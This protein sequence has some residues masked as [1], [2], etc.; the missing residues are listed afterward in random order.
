M[1]RN[2]LRHDRSCTNQR[3]AADRNVRQDYC[4]RADRCAPLHQNTPHR[5]VAR[6]LQGARR[7]DGPWIPVIRENRAGTDESASFDG[8]PVKQLSAILDLHIV[9]H[10]HRFVDIN[11]FSQDASIADRRLLAYLTLMPYSRPAT[12]MRSRRN[13]RRIVNRNVFHLDFRCPGELRAALSYPHASARVRH[14]RSAAIYLLR[15]ARAVNLR[16]A[17]DHPSP[18]LPRGS[19]S[20]SSR[21]TRRPRSVIRLTAMLVSHARPQPFPETSGQSSPMIVFLIDRRAS[22]LAGRHDMAI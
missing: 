21:A 9:S 5:P 1:W 22:Q 4:P 20:V 14:D 2:V 19:R 13:L 18:T 16:P 6:A 10:R 7:R 15:R 3:P 8:Y 12:H 17:T 11:I